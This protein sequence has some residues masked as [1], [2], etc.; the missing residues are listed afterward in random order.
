M[1]QPMPRAPPVIIAF[2]KGELRRVKP[3]EL[4]CSQ[5]ALIASEYFAQF[6]L[7]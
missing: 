3:T 7:I 5:N 2:R 4:S 1:P 6:F